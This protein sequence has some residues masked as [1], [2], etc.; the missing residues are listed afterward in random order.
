MSDGLVRT[1][2]SFADPASVLSLAQT[3]DGDLWFATQN[4]FESPHA[5]IRLRTYYGGGMNLQLHGVLAG[6]L[7]RDQIPWQDDMFGLLYAAG[8]PNKVHSRAFRC[9]DNPG[10][11][12]V[13]ALAGNGFGLKTACHDKKRNAIA[14][15]GFFTQGEGPTV[16]LPKDLYPAVYAGLVEAMRRK[17]YTTP[18]SV[19]SI[20]G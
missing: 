5:H 12:F 19:F 16:W 20:A 6:L 13:V 18:L 10:S 9:D 15:G 8:L 1:F 14:G 17:K 2:N 7:V 11:H 4:Q 3:P